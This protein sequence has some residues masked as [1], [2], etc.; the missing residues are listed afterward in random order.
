MKRL[1][2]SALAVAAAIAL[3]ACGSSGPKEGQIPED[4][5]EYLEQIKNE[6]YTADQL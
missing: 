4:A 1:V 6:E 3:A 2:F 5:D